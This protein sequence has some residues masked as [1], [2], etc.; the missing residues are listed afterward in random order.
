MDSRQ[1]KAKSWDVH[2]WREICPEPSRVATRAWG[3]VVDTDQISTKETCLRK[4]YMG[5]C[6]RASIVTA[7]TMEMFPR[8]AAR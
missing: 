6:R 7:A 5:V 8:N 3:R 2:A 1:T 4:K